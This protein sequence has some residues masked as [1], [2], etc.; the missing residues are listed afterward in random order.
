MI[1]QER[2]T[3][4]W[5]HRAI[6]YSEKI[7]NDM[8]SFKKNAWKTLIEKYL[9]HDFAKG[10]DIGAGPGFFSILMAGLGLDVSVVDCSLEMLKEAKSNMEV[11][12]YSANYINTDC[13]ELPFKDETFDFIIC[14]NLVWTLV[15]PKEAYLEWHRV[16]KKGG[17]LVVVDA[18]W[19]LRL[20]DDLLQKKYELNQK[21]A[22]E[23]GYINKEIS[24]AQEKECLYI[25]KNLPLSHERR[26]KWDRDTLFQ[27]AYRNIL[28]EED[29][30]DI[31]YD[32]R[33]KALYSYAPLFLICG[34][35]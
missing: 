30:S 16:L 5:E 8:N 18:N 20:S 28:I 27:C 3:N 13:H 33:Q 26:P 19:F 31:V 17:R 21:N 1:N 2:I 25:A 4:Y 6:D 35:K 9:N 23:L 14:R 32:G 22:I 15:S 10:L 11:A 12:G 34:E 29:I 7:K 24:E